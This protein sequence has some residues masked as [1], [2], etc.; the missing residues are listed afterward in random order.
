MDCDEI[1]VFSEGELKEHG[2]HD[3]LLENKGIYADVYRIQTMGLNEILQ[4]DAAQSEGR[5]S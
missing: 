4:K 1:F 3:S 2:T 5:V